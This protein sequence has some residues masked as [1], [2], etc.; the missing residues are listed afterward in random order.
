MHSDAADGAR[1]SVLALIALECA[2]PGPPVRATVDRALAAEL[3]ALAAIDIARHAP[4]AINLDLITVGAVYD[5]A[6]IL[7][8]GWPVHA[9]LG[10]APARFGAEQA[11]GNII[12]FGTHENRLPLPALQPDA[13]L[14][15]SPLLIMPWLLSGTAA[16][17][18]AVGA[19][20]ERDLLERGLVNADLALALGDAFGVTLEHARHLTVFDLCALTCAQY[21]HAGFG[22]LWQIIEAAV[23][24]PDRAQES[25]LPGGTRLHWREGRVDADGENARERAWAQAILAAHGIGHEPQP[26]G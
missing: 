21:E 24:R 8:P 2:A 22:A 3:A 16:A 25:V 14:Y 10:A 12:A 20:L 4:A 15:G 26:V 9:A 13:R 19:Q 7:R 18:A 1:S 11:G 6:Q 23:L 17:A 5:Q